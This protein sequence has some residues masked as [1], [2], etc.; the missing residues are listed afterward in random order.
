M[1]LCGHYQADAGTLAA[2]W[3]TAFPPGVYCCQ[4]SV[5]LR[6]PRVIFCAVPAV[7][8]MC[9]CLQILVQLTSKI[10]SLWIH[11]NFI[12]NIGPKAPKSS[13]GLKSSGIRDPV[14]SLLD[15]R[16]YTRLDGWAFNPSSCTISNSSIGVTAS[17]KSPIKLDS[18]S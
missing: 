6:A 13:P 18:K 4:R 10:T 17:G 11:P 2:G 14:L 1:R 16:A 5:C 3:K 12:Y 9:V 7:L 8:L 15:D